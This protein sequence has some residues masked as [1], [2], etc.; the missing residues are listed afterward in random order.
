[1]VFHYIHWII[2]HCIDRSLDHLSPG[3]GSHGKMIVSAMSKKFG[4]LKCHFDKTKTEFQSLFALKFKEIIKLSEK[5]RY[6]HNKVSLLENTLD[7][8]SAYIKRYF[9]NHYF[10]ESFQKRLPEFQKK[11][12]RNVFTGCDWR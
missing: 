10:P 5:V 3:F 11:K 2:D 1:M 8:E 9:Q 6:L 4:E 7:E 12:I